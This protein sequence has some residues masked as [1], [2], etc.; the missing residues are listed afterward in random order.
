M[1]TDH[2]IASDNHKKI[3]RILV[4]G[5]AGFIGGTFIDLL[6]TDEDT[7]AVLCFDKLTY[8]ARPDRVDKHKQYEKYH[9]IQGD[10]CDAAKVQDVIEQFKPDCIVNFAAES[11]VD[12]SLK[13]HAPFFKTNVEGVKI[14]LEN[15]VKNN[16]DY[17]VQVS[18]DEVYGQRSEVALFK[19]DSDYNPRNPYSKSKHKAEQLVLEFKRDESIKTL[20]TRGCNTLGPWQ[21]HEKLIPKVIINALNHEFIPVYGDGMQCREWISATDHAG[22][23]LHLIR[24]HKFG[25]VFNIGTG[26]E[27]RN[28]DMVR[29][30]LKELEK[31]HDLIQYVDDRLDHDFKYGVDT[32]SLRATGWRPSTD[33]NDEL[34][35]TIDF[36][37][38][39]V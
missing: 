32:E 15:C 2:H 30:I 27:R 34:N 16:I 35:S 36:Y 5:G 19:E 6:L 38:K 3:K 37:R 7:Q 13:D 11:H 10:I 14:L 8:A 9:F 21:H 29:G 22:A 28:I 23:I 18:T 31:S 20:I 39:R 4:T 25:E 1:K 24:S 17:F 33:I 26:A 12:N